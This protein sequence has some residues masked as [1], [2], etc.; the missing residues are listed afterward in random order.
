MSCACPPHLIWTMVLWQAAHWDNNIA[1]EADK[2]GKHFAPHA[3]KN[4]TDEGLEPTPVDTSLLLLLCNLPPLHPPPMAISDSDMA[5]VLFVAITTKR[6]QTLKNMVTVGFE[7][8]QPKLWQLEC[9]PLTARAN[10]P[11]LMGQNMPLRHPGIA[12][13]HSFT[14]TGTPPKAERI[15]SH[16]TK[17]HC[18]CK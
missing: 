14:H 12:S 6:H 8:T 1:T 10:D 4:S 18:V 9:H 15:K 3:Y 2:T 13:W 11:C 16:P 5:N 7:P 17:E